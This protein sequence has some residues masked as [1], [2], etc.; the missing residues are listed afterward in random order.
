Q[1]GSE[2]KFEHIEAA[3]EDVFAE[4]AGSDMEAPGGE[5]VENFR[6]K[7]M[8]LAEVRLRRIGA[9]QVE[10]LDGCPLMGVAFHTFARDQ[11]NGGLRL[12]REA[13]RG[14]EADGF[15]Q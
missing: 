10:V 15:D 7:E 3:S 13:V 12:L 14:A 8:D 4:S 2:G 11:A 6:S 9:Q 1:A 5:F